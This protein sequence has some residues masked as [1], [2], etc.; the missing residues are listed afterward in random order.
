MT[1]IGCEVSNKDT[2]HTDKCSSKTKKQT[3]KM[4]PQYFEDK[5]K[6]KV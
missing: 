2:K 3:K 5:T 1:T 6:K 4:K